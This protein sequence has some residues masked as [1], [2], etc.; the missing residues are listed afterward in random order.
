[1]LISPEYKKSCERMILANLDNKNFVVGPNHVQD[2]IKRLLSFIKEHRTDDSKILDIGS[3]AYM[4][5]VL[6]ATHACDVVEMAGDILEKSGWK[7]CFEIGS[8]D[9][10]PYKDKQ[11]DIAI[12]SEIIE[13]L[14]EMDS[15]VETF[16][17]IERVAK[18]WILTTP[19]ASKTGFRDDW[20]IEPSH[21][22]FLTFND[23]Q[24]LVEVTLPG[25]PYR[26]EEV[27]HYVV[28]IRE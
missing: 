2:R 18:K 12:C 28:V 1:M 20:N 21:L 25:I 22:Q 5:I 10:L 9:D 4:P 14:P 23:I 11:F 24:E 19:K 15:V 17:E 27:G 13:H 8:C 6:G 3:G 16:S 26:I 7:G